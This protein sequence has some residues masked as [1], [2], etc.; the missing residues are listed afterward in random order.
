LLALV[1]VFKTGHAAEKL[2]TSRFGTVRGWF[3]SARLKRAQLPLLFERQ[4]VNLDVF[5]PEITDS[6]DPGGD[7]DPNI[8]PFL[9]NMAV[10]GGVV[11]AD[12]QV[13]A[14]GGEVIFVLA[15]ELDCLS[16]NV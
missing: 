6:L 1:W 15:A 11:V 12:D 4:K 5:Y 3:S 13:G 14:I 7:H 8:W 2:S 10:F 16:C 9:R